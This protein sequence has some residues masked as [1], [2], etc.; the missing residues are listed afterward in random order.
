MSEEH[1][2]QGIPQAGD[3]CLPVLNITGR[4]DQKWE[5]SH[6]PVRIAVVLD[7]AQALQARV[8]ALMQ[9]GDTIDN[10]PEFERLV[11]ELY[12]GLR[13]KLTRQDLLWITLMHLNSR[14]SDEVNELVE[15]TTQLDDLD[16]AWG[17]ERHFGSAS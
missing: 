6:D 4:R 12:D 5:H 9:L 7:W 10:N 3:D 14:T 1:Q 13:D 16:S 8:Q 17:F 15:G 11:D 2:D